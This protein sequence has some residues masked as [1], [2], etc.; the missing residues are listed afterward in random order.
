MNW[1]VPVGVAG[2][3]GKGQGGVILGSFYILFYLKVAKQISND[4]GPFRQ[5]RISEPRHSLSSAII[6]DFC[7]DSTPCPENPSGSSNAR[8][9]S[10]N[11][12]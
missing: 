6:P 7:Q 5:A 2:K 3:R 11:K 1:P 4:I 12:F 10:S 8:I 9:H